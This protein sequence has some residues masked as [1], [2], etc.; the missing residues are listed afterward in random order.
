MIKEILNIAC[1]QSHL[2]WENPI[3]NRKIFTAKIKEI[4]DTTDIIFL[5][6]MFTTGFTMNA[7]EVAESMQGETLVWMQQMA[8]EKSCAIAGSIV[9]KEGNQYYNRFVFMK[10]D[11]AYE[12]YDKHH[13]FTLAKEHE[14]YKEGE[15][16][17]IITYKGWKI[18]PLICYD[19][20]FP[21]W[22]RN[23][24]DY[25]ALIYVASWPKPRIGAWD[26]LLK[27]RAI[28]N[29]SYCIGVNRV[30]LDGNGYEYNGHSAIYNA[31][32]DVC[33][34]K[35]ETPVE[36]EVILYASLQKSHL[37][38]LRSKLSFLNDADRFEL[39]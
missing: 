8:Q 37:E 35:E 21:V 33:H 39:V 32:G 17:L 3:E 30:G 31:L 19:L 13:L 9:I 38:T 14:T 29:M 22:A 18:K 1:I 20:R 23:V 2:A 5:P 27:A 15:K 12:L 25:D 4:P 24:E 34:E 16:Q 10:E 6:E 7:V 26:A 28:E 11:G 36:K